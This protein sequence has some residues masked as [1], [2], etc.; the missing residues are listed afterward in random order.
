MRRFSIL[1]V[2]IFLSISSLFAEVPTISSVTKLYVA[3]FNRAPDAAGLEYWLYDSGLSLEEIARS[4]FDQPETQQKYPPSLSVRDFIKEVYHNL[5]NR[6]PDPKGL[7][8]WEYELLSG[9]IHRSEFI[10]AVMNGAMYDDAVILSNKE[11]VGEYFAEAGLNDADEA[12]RVIAMIDSSY[13]SVQRAKSLIDEI[14]NGDIDSDDDSNQ[15]DLGND[16][17]LQEPD[18]GNDDSDINDDDNLYIPDGWT[19]EEA[20]ALDYLNQIRKMTGLEPYEPE[21]HL[22]ASA[23]NHSKYM[24]INDEMNHYEQEGK[25]GF[26]GEGLQDRVEYAG[27]TDYFA[28]GENIA[29]TSDYKSN[30][31]LLFNAIYHRKAFLSFYYTEIGVGRATDSDGYYQS[32]FTYDMGSRDW[33]S[34][35]DVA[36]VTYPVGTIDNP[37]FYDEYPKPIPEDYL[38]TGNPVSIFFNPDVVDC[39]D[40]TLDSFTL[41][42]LTTNQNV[43]IVYTLT[44]DSDKNGIFSDCDFAIFPEDGEEVGHSYKA[45]FK[46]SDSSGPHTIEWSF[47]VTD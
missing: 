37:I 30:V 13:D 28:I 45:T 34:S 43:P 31:D 14:A 27:Y 7:D 29:P 25:P 10:L 18:E 1:V 22:H 11:E 35:S 33:G 26:T 38:P 47:D 19:Q 20:K 23:Q 41:T 39:S 5:F 24:V 46:Y 9:N 40:I 32:M 42:D 4:F 8:Y 21:S 2:W 16:D 44:S 6:D 17:T 12:K 15:I 3:T 36:Y